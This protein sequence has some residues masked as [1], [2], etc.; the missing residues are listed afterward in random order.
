MW[1]TVSMGRRKVGGQSVM[2]VS[3]TSVLPFSAILAGVSR[4]TSDKAR[5]LNTRHQRTSLSKAESLE[6]KSRGPRSYIG[7]KGMEP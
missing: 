6:L 7:S 4:R 1:N 2:E 5:I 3:R